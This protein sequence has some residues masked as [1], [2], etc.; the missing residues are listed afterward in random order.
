MNR[1]TGLM[2]NQNLIKHIQNQKVEMDKLQ[3]QLATGQKI[4]RPGE[5]PSNAANQMYFKT[6]LIETQQFEKNVYEAI[7]RINLT[8]GQLSTITDILQR[9]RVL[10]VQASNG[11]YQGDN[12]F[13]LK[14]AIASEIDQHLRALIDIANT[15]DATGRPLFG[16]FFVERK[17]FE[18]IVADIETPDGIKLENQIIGVEY[19][20]DIGKRLVEIDRN[21]YI[22]VNLPGNRVFW[23]TN[24]VIVGN[25]DASGYIAT[26]NQKFK[27]N[28]VT[29]EVN[30]GDTIDD[31]IDKIN[32]AGIEV[33][34]SKVGQDNLA[35]HTITPH[36]IWLEDLEGGTVLQDL[37]LINPD[38]PQPPN[39]YNP[40]ARVEGLSLF[41]VLIKFRNDLL[42]GDQLE[43]SGQDIGNLDV[44]LENLLRYR[45]ELGARHNRLEEFAKK[46]SWDKITL[47]ELV[48]KT[49]GIDYAET[50]MN[51][52]WIENV[53]NYSLNVGARIIRPTLLDF[54][55]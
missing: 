24:M 34:A 51:L 52:K 31:I 7:D 30:I 8:D 18:P 27:I 5:A 17:P 2:Q 44:A 41:D 46:I 47:T 13:D 32:K 54:I 49:E 14:H 15:T 39:N 29:I 26:S 23:G 53:Y 19:R 43:I 40:L 9:V 35:L 42:K 4:T 33:R 10:A 38:Q 1:I 6:R 21:E 37:G 45:S 16:G 3:N 48:A 36:Q 20:G 12:A 28:D 11:I 50:I 22:D 55:R 25:V